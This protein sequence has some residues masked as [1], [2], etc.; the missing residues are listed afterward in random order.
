MIRKFV[1]QHSGSVG[2]VVASQ[3]QGSRIAVCVEFLCMLFP[4][5]TN[6]QLCG[7]AKKKMPLGINRLQIHH[8]PE[9]Y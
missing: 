9:S 8:D 2:R 3:L 4:P 1:G 6:V 7:L 5:P